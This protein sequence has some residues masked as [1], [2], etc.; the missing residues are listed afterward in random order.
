MRKFIFIL[1]FLIGASFPISAQEKAPDTVRLS[2]VYN[3]TDFPIYNKTTDVQN[4][5]GFSLEGDY[6]L[7]RS[8]N[9]RLSV[10]YNFQRKLNQEVFPDYPTK[11]GMMDIYRDVDTHSVGGQFGYSIKG[12]VEPFAGLFYGARKIHESTPYQVVRFV[13]FGVN[14]PFTKSSHFFIKGYFQY[15]QP[16]GALPVGFIN[17]YNRVFGFGAGGRF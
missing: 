2:V 11:M 1:G 8:G 6:S 17:P 5:N 9:A 14:I 16:Y 13:R 3:R 15:E 4:V 7:H 12:S 10:A